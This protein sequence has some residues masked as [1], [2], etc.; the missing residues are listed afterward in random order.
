ML[1]RS[2]RGI[3]RQLTAAY[4][5]QQNGVAE[6]KNRTLVEAARCM[7]KDA[8]I[9]SRFWAKAVHTVAYLQNRSPTKALDGKTPEEVYSG[10]KPNVSHL[11]VFGCEAYA[12][13]PKERRQ[14]LMTNL[15][16]VSS[17]DMLLTQKHISGTM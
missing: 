12:H 2:E 4:S 6:R 14:S 15:K 16:S 3:F 7:L 10:Y 11:R 1:F 9:G 17:L 8:N 13:V 5:A